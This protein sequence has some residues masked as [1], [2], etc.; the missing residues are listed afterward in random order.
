MGKILIGGN[1][2][3]KG[4]VGSTEIN[5]MILNGVTIYESAPQLDAPTNVSVSR[6]EASFDP[7]ENAESYEFFVDGTSIGT[8][9]ES[10]GYTVSYTINQFEIPGKASL[11][12]YDGTD[13]TGTLL[14]DLDSNMSD[15]ITGTVTCSS[16]NL[17]IVAEG[18]VIYFE[19]TSTT[20][21]VTYID[22]S[23]GIATFTVSADGT[24]TTN[25]IYDD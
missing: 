7:V 2:F 5:K 10:S 20:G 24:L 12:I 9:T 13:D 18:Y 19:S 14:A 6:T 3:S 22:Y 25:V 21:G 11:K 15:T 4:F 16:G 17:A 23:Q 1:A 8:Y